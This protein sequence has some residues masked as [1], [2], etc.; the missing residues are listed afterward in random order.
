MHE[1]ALMAELKQV[2]DQLLSKEPGTRVT[3]ARLWIGA[4]SHLT[5]ED[6]RQRWAETF[7]Q[8]PA[9]KAE[10]EVECSE[11]LEDPRALSV[12]LVDLDLAPSVPA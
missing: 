9:E 8:T 2:V 10:L 1:Q 4:L 5:E 6:L 11:D 12:V 7:A 3:R